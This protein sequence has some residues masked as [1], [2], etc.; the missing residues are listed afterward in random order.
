MA[1]DAFVAPSRTPADLQGGS[2]RTTGAPYAAL[3]VV[4]RAEALDGRE[5]S[6]LEGTS[7]SAARSTF[8]A[9][10]L[11]GL[12]TAFAAGR[13]RQLRSKA[14]RQGLRRRGTETAQ[15]PILDYQLRRPGGASMDQPVCASILSTATCWRGAVQE[16]VQ[17]ARHLT[18]CRSHKHWDFGVVFVHGHDRVSVAQIANTLDAGLGTDGC[19]LVV[20]VDGCSGDW[21][22]Q[23]RGSASDGSPAISLCGVQLPREMKPR[24]EPNDHSGKTQLDEPVPFFIGKQELSEISSLASKCQAAHESYGPASS[25]LAW[26]RYLGVPE[27]ADINGILL[28]QDPLSSNRVKKEAMAG[29][30]LA[31][32]GAV[33]CGGVASD[34][35]PSR[36]RMALARSGNTRRQCAYAPDKAGLCGIILPSKMTLHTVVTP[37]AV[38][39]GPEMRISKAEKHVISQINDEPAKQFLAAAMNQMGS[40]EQQMVDRSGLLMGLEALDD[41][42]G[43][44]LDL[45]TAPTMSA[46]RRPLT[47]AGLEDSSTPQDW[48]LRSF[49]DMFGGDAVII[50]REDLSRV[51]ASLPSHRQ[52]RRMQLHVPDCSWAQQEEK[53]NFQRYLGSRMM[54]APNTS[55]P[56]GA[57]ALTCR[58][59]AQR[60]AASGEAE[61]GLRA[62]KETIGDVPVAGARVCGEIA[63]AGIALGGTTQCRTSQ[64]GHAS[65]V[66]IFGYEA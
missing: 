34:L 11:A 15:R 63:S 12:G 35:V 40:V 50:R 16:I 14:A 52:W 54:L 61:V 25:T 10:F 19:L 29:L 43:G 46:E 23:M 18:A 28:F 59:W 20:A 13:Q 62:I 47:Q 57:M 39:V 60:A 38:R 58:H 51:P 7:G 21:S 66:C 49:D 55:I 32:P 8:Q 26:R 41:H 33:K 17:E 27:H 45:D 4:P 48:I 65:A 24:K 37:G 30:D 36:L 44:Q 3:R 6:D 22:K 53:L 56:F 64:H 9:A 1:L 5:P 31:F 2:L 42:V